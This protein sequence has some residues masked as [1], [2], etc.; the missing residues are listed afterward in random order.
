VLNQS[1]SSK[2]KKAVTE[3]TLS[4]NHNNFFFSPALAAQDTALH[5][6]VGGGGGSVANN[7]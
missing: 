6:P 5:A 7:M 1:G 4:F 2:S 3:Q